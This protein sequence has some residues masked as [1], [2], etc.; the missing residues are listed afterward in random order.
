MAT[1]LYEISGLCVDVEYMIMGVLANNVYIVSDGEGTMVV[2]P[3]C[4]A[5][6]ILAA[7][8]ER[9]LDAIV[10]THSHFDHTGAAAELREATGAPVIASAIDAPLIEEP[11]DE[12]LSTRGV[13]CPVD[14]TVAHGDVVE[15]GNMKWKVIA[16]PGHTPGSICLFD[17]PQFGNHPKGLPVLLSGDTLLGFGL[18]WINYKVIGRM[19]RNVDRLKANSFFKWAQICSGAGVAFMHGAQDGQKF[20]S[21]FMLAIMMTA[22]MGMDLSGV[23]MPMWLMIFCAFNMGLGTAVG[24]ERIIKSVGMDMVKLE[25]FQGFAAS[26]STFVSLML[27][28]FGGLPV[29]TTHTN[30]TAIMGVGAAKSPKSVKW[31]IAIDM[32][33]TWVLTFPGCGIL[34]FACAK[35][36]LMIL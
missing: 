7:L 35:L 24:G 22:G 18:G 1:D 14:R 28:T 25:A 4:S 23:A 30:T 29:S 34:G 17:I 9:K 19:C 12:D 11:C 5:D 33:K 20:M 8:G 27:A 36:F 13:P 6:K 26:L 16:T 10:L 3:S 21:I 2:D 15:V 31:S 32:V